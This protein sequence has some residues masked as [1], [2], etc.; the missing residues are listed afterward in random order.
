[1]SASEKQPEPQ[2]QQ[3]SQQPSQNHEKN[4]GVTTEKQAHGDTKNWRDKLVF[5]ALFAV[6]GLLLWLL[7]LSYA[8]FNGKPLNGDLPSFLRAAGE[9]TYFYN[10]GIREPLHPLFLRL[11]LALSQSS[12]QAAR[13]ST[14][15]YSLLALL[16]LYWSTSRLFDRGTALIASLLFALN[17]V[18]IYYGVSGLRAPLFT[19]ELLVISAL[20]LHPRRFEKPR[21]TALALGLVMSLA[22]LTRMHAWIFIFGAML[23]VILRD[24]LWQ[25]AQR[26]WLLWMSLALVVSFVIYL[27]YPLIN[28]SRAATTAVNFWRNVEQTGQAGTF[29]TDPPRST[30]SYVFENRSLLDVVRRVFFNYLLYLRDYIP[31]LLGFMR[32]LVWLLPVGLFAAWRQK[33]L[34]LILFT[35]LSLAQVVFILN[36]RQTTH[37]RGIETRFVYQSLPFIL[38][39]IAL[40]LREIGLRLWQGLRLLGAQKET[41][42]T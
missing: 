16:A 23:V 20:L 27:P 4:P 35:V 9:A 29:L 30:L 10:S 36:V 32:V 42:K 39:A 33:K 31:Q 6:S 8:N 37:A 3:P 25:K 14:T 21:Q 5:W 15:V 28:G 1:M 24:K 41:R 34:V 13:L 7:S 18:V 17:P 2:S 40:A 12:E 19:A 38:M 26:P 22:G 11:M